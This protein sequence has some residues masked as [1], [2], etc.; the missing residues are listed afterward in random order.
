MAEPEKSIVWADGDAY[1]KF[2][3]QWSRLSGLDFVKWIAP[4]SGL[5]WLDVGCGTGAFTSI[6]L[7]GCSP[8]LIVGIDPAEV[9]LADAKL[10]VMDDR[11]EFRV[12]DALALPFGDDEFDIA[13][14]ALVLNFVPDQGKMVAEMA[15]VVRPSGTVAAYVW[16][17]AGGKGV[18][19][20]IGAAVAAQNTQASGQASNIQNT[21]STRLEALSDLFVEAG[22]KAVETRPIEITVTFENFED[23]WSSNTGFTSPVGNFVKSL[24]PDDCDRFMGEVKERLPIG[25]DG[26]IQYMARV[27]AVRGIVP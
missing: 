9:H 19:Q 10:R 26:S 4:D 8:G 20:H 27:S 25:N 1:E 18:S 3:G 22:L 21:E 15:R 11:V 16:D 23:Y 7:E 5:K 12:A 17:F 2:M 13:A 14:S 24:S 6:V